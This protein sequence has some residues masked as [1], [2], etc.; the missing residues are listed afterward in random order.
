M[1]KTKLSE[2][3][4]GLDMGTNS[5][6]WS[7]IEEEQG[8][9]KNFIDCGSRIFIRSV[10][11]KTPTPKNQHRRAKRLLRRVI[12][13]RHRRKLRLRNYL[14]SRGFLPET[15][16]DEPNLESEFNKLGDPYQIRAKGLDDILTPHEFGRAIMHLGTRRGFLSNRKTGFGNLREDLEAREILEIE[17]EAAETDKDEGKFKEDIKKLREKISENGKRTLG[18]YLATLPRKR[19]RGELH[20]LR[21]DRRMYQEEFEKIFRKQSELNPKIYTE[22]VRSAIE[23]IIFHQRP[24]TWDKKTIGNC[25]LEPKKRRVDMGRLEFQQFRYWQDINN[26]SW[27]DTETGEKDAKPSPD[28]K[29]LIAEALEKKQKSDMGKDQRKRNPQPE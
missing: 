25:S 4:I 16:K 15:L 5:I 7:V 1:K 23:K 24:V 3:A 13:R 2:Y 8:K 6:G 17:D 9:P 10:E 21:T 29:K 22:D 12:E 27:D 20:D 14:I 28:Q 19:N 26:L 11:D 18:E